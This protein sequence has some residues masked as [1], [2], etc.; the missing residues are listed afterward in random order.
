MNWGMEGELLLL[1]IGIGC[2]I[3]IT[4]RKIFLEFLIFAVAAI[5]LLNII[6]W[7]QSDFRG[8]ATGGILV[9]AVMPIFLNRRRLAQALQRDHPAELGETLAMPENRKT[10]LVRVLKWGLWGLWLIMIGIAAGIF[11]KNPYLQYV[12]IAIIVIGAASTLIARF[13]KVDISN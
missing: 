8:W 7:G 6:V 13:W 11:G 1:M 3:W 5:L 12:F 4:M 9:L 10:K 2:F